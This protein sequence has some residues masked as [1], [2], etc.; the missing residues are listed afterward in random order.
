[1]PSF[2]PAPLPGERRGGFVPQ[3]AARGGPTAAA[4]SPLPGSPAPERVADVEEAP[5][6]NVY[7]EGRAAGRAE[8]PWREAE[9]LRSAVEA[10]EGMARGLA[11]LQRTYLRAHRRC[12][13]DLAL[14]VAEKLL[15]RA[16]EAEPDALTGILERAIE[17]L[18]E[19]PATRVNL[20]RRDSEILERGLAPD[21]ARLT[22]EHGIAV[23]AD[24]NLAPGDVR[25]FAGITEVDGRLSELLRRMREELFEAVEIEPSGEDR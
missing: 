25:V 24:P 20:S 23:E 8:L 22:H 10:C 17:A 5:G 9:D 21:L 2:D 16:I 13:V 14:A 12:L 15:G 18:D 3:P 1:M 4:L 6:Q 11:A 7:E 19:V